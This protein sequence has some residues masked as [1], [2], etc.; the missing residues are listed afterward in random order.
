MGDVADLHAW[1]DLKYYIGVSLELLKKTTK[2]SVKL[3]GLQAEAKSHDLSSKEE[4]RRAIAQAD[5]RRLSTSA[6][7]ARVQVKSCGICGGQS[8]T[9]AGFL[10]VLRFPLPILIPPTAPRSSLILGWYNRPV[11]SRRTEWTQCHP[12]PRKLK[13]EEECCPLKDDDG[14]L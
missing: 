10:R 5:S 2:D 12:T 8:D 9:V 13:K 7:R 11:S 3:G 4:E 1:P 14:F 6:A